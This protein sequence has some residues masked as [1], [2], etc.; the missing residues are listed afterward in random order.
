MSSKVLG[1]TWEAQN[2]YLEI[3]LDTERAWPNVWTRRKL[4]KCIAKMYDPLGLVAPVILLGKV[5]L[6]RSWKEGG[7]WDAPCSD[8]LSADCQQWQE[9]VIRKPIFQVPRWLGCKPHED[10]H[11]HL[12]TDASE[13][14]FGCCIYLVS[15]S[16]KRLIFAKA[17]VASLV[18]QTLAR[19]E[20]QAAFVGI[21]ALKFVCKELR[22]KP[23]SVS[24]WTD[25]STVLHWIKKP[26]YE[27]TIRG[28]RTECQQYSKSI[29]S[30]M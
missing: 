28:L 9:A 21:R 29:R 4:L 5:L 14:A 15:S 26:A 30:A 13:K 23:V 11:L 12:F 24:A 1:I 3:S 17:R 19:L 10:Q 18:V 6:Q 20:L 27:W 22:V 2:D 25:S 16:C 7:E 8:I